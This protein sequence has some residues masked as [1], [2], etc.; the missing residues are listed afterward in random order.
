MKS[1]LILITII[2]FAS[3]LDLSIAGNLFTSIGSLF[4]G[5]VNIGTTLSLLFDSIFSLSEDSE[6][7][8]VLT[9][10]SILS[11]PTLRVN[12]LLNV[13]SFVLNG[14]RCDGTGILN[15]VGSVN[16]NAETEISNILHCGSA[17][18]SD[19]VTATSELIVK[20]DVLLNAVLYASAGASLT[21]GGDIYG[22]GEVHCHNGSEILLD[23]D[24]MALVDVDLFVD[25]LAKILVSGNARLGGAMNFLGELEIDVNANVTLGSSLSGGDISVAGILIIDAD[26]ILNLAANIVI[27]A[28]GKTH[29]LCESLISGS[30]EVGAELYIGAI[31]R[32]DGLVN[33]AVGASVEVSV[34]ASVLFNNAITGTGEIIVDGLCT[35]HDIATVGAEL[36]V[37]LKIGNGGQVLCTGHNILTGA[38]SLVGD[39]DVDVDAILILST[40]IS[41]NGL[42]NIEGLLN[43]S[44]SALV[45]VSSDVSVAASGVLN[46]LSDCLLSSLLEIGSSVHV[47]SLGHLNVSGS[48]DLLVDALLHIEG[49]LTCT[50]E[51]S[52]DLGVGSLV[53]VEGSVALLCDV[54]GDGEVEFC[55]DGP[56]QEY[57]PGNEHPGEESEIGC[58]KFDPLI[59]L[60]N[61]AIVRLSAEVSLTSI[62]GEGSSILYVDKSCN[63]TGNV[64][65][66]ESA[67]FNLGAS[68]SLSIGGNC[69]F[70]SGTTLSI[71]VKVSSDIDTHKCLGIVGEATLGGHLIINLDAE[72]SAGTE[73]ILATY[74]SRSTG[75]VF[76]SLTV[77]VGEKRS[78][79]E[80]QYEVVYEDDRTYVRKLG[81]TESTVV[82]DFGSFL[83]LAPMILFASMLM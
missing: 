1:V 10:G 30:L 25:A 65:I 37:S 29:I 57:I 6:V 56:P 67:S 31:V 8:G 16:I 24:V 43:I 22:S 14:G 39:L 44:A 38:I 7:H 18:I 4:T 27:D 75:S 61:L 28:T 58:S 52:L 53:R 36:G 60:K 78:L 77:N 5:D 42:V 71:D 55:N 41:G 64:N 54:S 19:S 70:G 49:S 81:E 21:I 32:V 40:G 80:E 17:M 79:E 33:L 35:L 62:I 82:D 20:G 9:L 66:S 83:G 34:G 26:G 50:L 72:L 45:E 76:A 51:A 74:R 69:A 23:S 2:T 68:V 47:S 15:V 13:S 73:I 46:I 12:A 48:V 59:H 63:A 11:T 3:A